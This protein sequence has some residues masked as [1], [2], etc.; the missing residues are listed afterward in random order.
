MK[1]RNKHHHHKQTPQAMTQNTAPVSEETNLTIQKFPHQAVMFGDKGDPVI[2]VSYIEHEKV[3]D[4][5]VNSMMMLGYNSKIFND[6]S[7]AAVMMH[8]GAL[9]QLK[10]NSEIAALNKRGLSN[11]IKD[12]LKMNVLDLVY[13]RVLGFAQ[14]AFMADA[15]TMELFAP[16]IQD[17]DFM[18]SNMCQSFCNYL[19]GSEVLENMAAG[20]YNFQVA[21]GILLAQS[22]LRSDSIFSAIVEYFNMFI[23]KSYAK[24]IE[25]TSVDIPSSDSYF[26][27]LY[28]RCYGEEAAAAIDVSKLS[29]DY[30]YSFCTSVLRDLAV[31]YLLEIRSGFSSIMINVAN[32]YLN[33]NIYTGSTYDRYSNEIHD[34]V[35]ETR[36]YTG[37]DPM[38]VVANNPY[39]EVAAKAIGREEYDNGD[40]E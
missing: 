2:P 27:A 10:K 6:F 26:L 39:L 7:T 15:G 18:V 8:T 36:G 37:D 40:N 11:S 34:Y 30:K 35:M 25:Y 33:G 32:M 20:K 13:N 28:K 23:M 21:Q 24:I 14:D 31:P 29:E 5:N 16:D 22:N 12:Y 38:S 4:E 1:L 3:V 19:T 9:N 17:V